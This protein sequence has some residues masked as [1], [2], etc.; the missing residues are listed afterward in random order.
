[1]LLDL[2]YSKREIA[3]FK[4]EENRVKAIISAQNGEKIKTKV[5]TFEEKLQRKKERE[6][7][8]EKEKQTNN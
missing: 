1:M 5:L 2:G 7:E 8:R 6:K 3:G 4:K